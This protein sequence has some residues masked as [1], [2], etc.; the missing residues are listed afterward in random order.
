MISSLCWTG[1]RAGAPLRLAQSLQ[2]APL[3]LVTPCSGP[4]WDG[5]TT[6]QPRPYRGSVAEMAAIGLIVIRHRISEGM[7]LGKVLLRESGTVG[8]EIVMRW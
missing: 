8:K 1:L 7:G 3:S 5:K 4:L 2:E 6:P